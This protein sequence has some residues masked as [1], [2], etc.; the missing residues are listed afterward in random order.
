MDTPE[1]TLKRCSSKENCVHPEAVD[2]WLPATKAYFRTRNIS[3]DGLHP[4]CN[5]CRNHRDRQRRGK[6]PNPV[7]GL[8]KVQARLAER[9][10]RLCTECVQIK[11]L[12]QFGAH[13]STCFPCAREQTR[14]YRAKNPEVVAATK[15]RYRA[16]HSARLQAWRAVNWARRSA[17]KRDLPD[18]FSQ[19]DWQRALD[20]FNGCCAICG[21]QLTNL[22]GTHTAAADHWIPLNAADCPGT[23]PT[24]MIPLCHGEGGCNNRKKDRH[25][26]E[27][28]ESTLGK[29]R[30]SNILKRVNDYFDMVRQ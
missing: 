10:E 17:R 15:K 11:S 12:D 5:A 28:L 27:F 29:R 13:S 18:A 2:G 25:P 16:K 3:K 6:N 14:N 26:V 20:Y 30:A 21:R 22:F 9:G 4:N 23:V 7:V 24:N 19:D 1:F 8:I